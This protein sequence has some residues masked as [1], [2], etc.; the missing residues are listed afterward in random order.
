MT[1]IDEAQFRSVLGHFASGVV[2]VTGMSDGTPCGFTCQS[3]FS[4]SLDPPLVAIA[5][6]KASA[7]WPKVSSQGEICINMLE[8]GQEGLAR[9][10]AVSG[11]EKYLSVDWEPAKNGAPRLHGCLAWIDCRIAAIHDAG[12]HHLVVAEVSDLESADGSPLLFY[13]GSFGL[14]I[15]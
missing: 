11:A 13:R 1:A 15:G 8:A 12:D 4:V 3:F 10:F 6:G 5:P 2:I 9:T 7:S 14:L